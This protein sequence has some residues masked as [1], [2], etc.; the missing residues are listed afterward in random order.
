MAIKQY[1]SSTN[2]FL[3]LEPYKDFSTSGAAI[4]SFIIGYYN[5]SLGAA[6]GLTYNSDAFMINATNGSCPDG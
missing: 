3:N 5:N 2:T 4:D 6:G 1:S